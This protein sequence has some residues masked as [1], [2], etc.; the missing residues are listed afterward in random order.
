MS[1]LPAERARN[2]TIAAVCNFIEE[3]I[4]NAAKDLKTSITIQSET[5]VYKYLNNPNLD[6]IKKFEEAGYTVEQKGNNYPGALRY[7]IS[8]RMPGP[9]TDTS[10]K[11][12]CNDEGEADFKEYMGVS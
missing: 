9:S 5:T 2:L 1:I 3:M 4:I 10:G 12:V 7:E 8:W 11:S 6:I